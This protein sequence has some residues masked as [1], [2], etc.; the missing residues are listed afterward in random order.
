MTAANSSRRRGLMLVLSSPSGAGKSTLSRMLLGDDADID[1]SVSATT[2]PARSGEIDGKDYY[3]VSQDRFTDMVDSDELLEYATVFSNRYGTPRKPVEDALEAGKDVLFD[4]D[5]Q[6]TQQLSQS[7]MKGD[8]VRVFILP[9]SIGELE[10][11]LR[12]RAKDPEDVVQARMSEA[13]TEISHWAEYDY[14]L[15]ND[16]L[17]E[18]YNKLVNILAVERAKT[19]RQ[20]DLV[21]FVR[22]LEDEHKAL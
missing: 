13:M 8:L 17:D 12:T 1:L 3:F 4:I 7:Q 2:R 15:V 11:R 16:D 21:A 10:S 20:V 14:V 9:P 18:T 6:G 5:W 22:A 19:V